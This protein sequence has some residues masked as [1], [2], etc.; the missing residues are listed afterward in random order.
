MGVANR[1]TL[2]NMTAIAAIKSQIVQA[3]VELL[4]MQFIFGLKALET[5]NHYNYA[6]SG[7]NTNLKPLSDFQT[8]QF[9]VS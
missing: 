4:S 1:L 7:C 9:L 5:G 8:R 2:H 6:E 3:Q